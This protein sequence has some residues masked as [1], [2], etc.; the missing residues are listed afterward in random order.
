MA[1]SSASSYELT[2]ADKEYLPPETACSHPVIR[3]ATNPDIRVLAALLADPAFDPSA[4]VS[5]NAGAV[6][7]YDSALLAAIRS[8]LPANT[9]FLL[10]AGA[11]PNGLPISILAQWAARYLRF[12][13][14]LPTT[15]TTRRQDLIPV[16]P[17]PQLCP[18][19]DAEFA[20]RRATRARFWAEPDFPPLA[21]RLSPPLTALSAA[22]HAGDCATIDALLVHG[23]DTAAWIY[24]TSSM[25]PSDPGASYLATST[26]LHAALDARSM[27]TVAH[28]LGKGF[29]PTVIPP[30]APTC[31]LSALM[32]TLTLEP[33]WMEAFNLLASS[34]GANLRVRTPVYGVH[35]LHIAAATL[36]L[37]VL[38]EVAARVPLR[39]AGKTALR[40]TLLHVACLPAGDAGV[41]HF[42]AK[43]HASVHEVRAL[44]GEWRRATL[45]PWKPR[46]QMRDA[47]APFKD[48]GEEKG[49]EEKAR[50]RQEEVV[51]WLVEAMSEDVDA[52]AQDV[53]G[54]TALHY[55]AGA[56]VVNEGLV[57]WL[58]GLEGWEEVWLGKRNY[59]GY[60]PLELYEDGRKVAEEMRE[61][62]EREEEVRYMPHWRDLMGSWVMGQWKSGY[63]ED[64][65]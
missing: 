62:G 40:H 28:L 58:R 54:N 24:P 12:R 10:S 19:T 55:L 47:E 5:P 59:W 14:Y 31:G 13:P 36:D 41:Q 65:K 11:D 63:P 30:S 43:V 29:S 34:L 39:E 44:S 21:T 37:S 25:D 38:Q 60:T 1:A 42:S 9:S 49:I 50:R 57:R 7:H 56:R 45:W 27:P 64:E 17:H 48:S 51:G 32:H 61:R 8:T 18:P 16:L 53:H 35:V 23:A 33:P 52:A 26:P 2:A 6:F 20:A 46:G 22:A 4:S 3:A 15:S